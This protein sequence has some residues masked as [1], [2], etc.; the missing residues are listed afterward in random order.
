M[1]EMIGF[2]GAGN[3]ARA[4]ITGLIGAGFPAANVLVSN[5]SQIKLDN[6]SKHLGVSTT[7]DNQVV[8]AQAKT[9]FLCVKPQ[10]LEGVCR[11]IR[12]QL[13]VDSCVISIAAG[14]SFKL[15]QSYLPGVTMLRVMPNLAVAINRGLVGVYDPSGVLTSLRGG[16]IER[17]MALLGDV[18]KVD[19]ESQ[20][21]ALTVIAASGIAF[22]CY[23]SEIVQRVA[24]EFDLPE[25]IVSATADGTA[26]LVKTMSGDWSELRY[27]VTSPGGTT[28]AAVRRMDDAAVGL[29]F[30]EA[31]DQAVAKAT[32]INT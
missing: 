27:Q 6:L 23:F 28:E 13:E 30:K 25:G 31:I 20:F 4:M 7:A 5:R 29:V 18:K 21:A 3:M 1:N 10:Q 19:D 12:P 16:A 9:L 32:N 17:S 11:Q 24:D 15:L 2:I 26:A 22:Y 14:V 8:A